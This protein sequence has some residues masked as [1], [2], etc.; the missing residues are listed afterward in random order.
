MVNTLC[1]VLNGPCR[2]IHT[3]FE[4]G[5]CCG[6]SCCL[7]HVSTKCACSEDTVCADLMGKQKN[8]QKMFSGLVEMWYLSLKLVCHVPCTFMPFY[9][10]IDTVYRTLQRTDML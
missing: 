5:W 10:K 3:L 2:G 9:I 8:S 7:V 1:S 6:V 4:K